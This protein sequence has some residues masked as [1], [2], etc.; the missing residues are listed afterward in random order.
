MIQVLVTGGT[1]YVAG[2]LIKQL[3]EK[4]VVVNAT[5]RNPDNKEK[6][7]HLRAI[8][9]ELNGQLKFLK[10]DLLRDG[11]FDSAMQGC[12]HVFHTAS[13]F[14]LD[15][16][17]VQKD[18]ID[19]ALKGTQNVLEAVNR[20][21]S[22]KRV[23]LTSSTAAIFGDNIDAQNIP[24]GAFDESHWNTSSS[25]EHSP[26]SFSKTLAEKEAWKINKQQDKWSLVVINPSLVLGPAVNPLAGS[27]SLKIMKQLGDGSLKSGIPHL[28]MGVVDVRDV[29]QAHIEVAF[30][31]KTQGRHIICGH[32]SFFLEIAQLISKKYPKYPLPKKELPKFLVWLFGPLINKAMTRKYVSRNIGYPWKANNSKSKEELKMSYRDLESTVQEHFGQLIENKLV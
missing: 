31:E 5:V 22:V 10:A 18:L 16:K 4:G 24:G 23:V 11:D 29:A 25:L 21:D 30:N 19:P 1:G 3:L 28:G 9:N 26:Y 8:A 2:E 13:P 7:K 17:D 15:V 32:N 14:K 12:S 6:T 27:E 20:S